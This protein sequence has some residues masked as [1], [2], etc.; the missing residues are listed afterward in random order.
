[1]SSVLGRL[2]GVAAEQHSLFTVA[3]AATV[4]LGDDQVRRM[5][6]TGVLEWRA[7]GVYRIS[8]VPFNEYAELLEAVC[9]PR[10]AAAGQ[11]ASGEYP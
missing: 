6:A 5:A 2:L 3:Q 9:G 11:H 10:A 7:Q 4:D 1:M 8:A